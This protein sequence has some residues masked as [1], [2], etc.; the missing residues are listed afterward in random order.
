MIKHIG[1]LVL[2]VLT[3]LAVAGDGNLILR[4]RVIT[5][6][7]NDDS[8]TILDTGTRVEVDD[9]VVPEFDLSYFISENLAFEIIA[10]VSPHELSTAD[11][12]LAGADAGEVWVL[13]PTLTIQYHFGRNEPIDFYAGLGINYT[14]FYSYDTSEDLEDLGVD[15]ID[16]D[17]SFGLAANLGIDFAIQGN[18]VFNI[19]VKYIDLAT[20]AELELEVGGS[21]TTLDVD[22]NPI[23]AG[24]GFG[25]RF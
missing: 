18:W 1:C 11:G 2:A 15:D 12:A 16:F 9:S 21:L 4:G 25:Y 22:I 7:P 23:V 10:A 3:S 8:S 14:T 13:P 19:D 6:A 24:I 5:V 17:S 20:D